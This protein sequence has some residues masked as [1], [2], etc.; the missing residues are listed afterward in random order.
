M[1]LKLSPKATITRLEK[2]N[3]QIPIIMHQN[4]IPWDHNSYRKAWNKGKFAVCIKMIWDVVEKRDVKT[5]HQL[6][7]LHEICHDFYITG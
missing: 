3:M 6:K 2:M 5:N 1:V 4:D 7:I